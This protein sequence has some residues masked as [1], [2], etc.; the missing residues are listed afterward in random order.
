MLLSERSRRV[1]KSGIRFL[2]MWFQASCLLHHFGRTVD[3][4]FFPGETDVIYAYDAL[5]GAYVGPVPRIN[6]P[7]YDAE[8][9]AIAEAQ[10]EGLTAAASHAK[11]ATE[12]LR[13]TRR[14]TKKEAEATR[15]AIREMERP[16]EAVPPD[17]EMDRDFNDF[18]GKGSA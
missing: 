16:L 3:I 1:G 18:F 4:K 15:A 9:H 12:T 11:R 6:T 2:G 14:Q 17:T 13:A 7:F 8:K 10:R 5:T